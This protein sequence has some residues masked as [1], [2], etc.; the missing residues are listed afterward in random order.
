M[1][2]LE[3]TFTIDNAPSTPSQ[4]LSPSRK[5]NVTTLLDITRA[6]NIGMSSFYFYK[7]LSYIA[8]AIMLSRI[9]MNFPE[10]RKALLDL[11]DDKLSFDDL[12]AISKQLPTAEEAG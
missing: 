8:I 2:D 5:Q 6:N 11:N 7:T 10:I 9:K 3:A 4:I 12:K 1:E